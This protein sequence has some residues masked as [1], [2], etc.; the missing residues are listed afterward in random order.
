V[1]LPIESLR[2]DGGTQ[3]RAYITPDIAY[4]YGDEMQAGAKFPP[5]VVFY[6][7]TD[8]WLADGFHRVEG[9][10]SVGIEQIECDVR[11][12][13]VE[14]A[15]WLSF[16]VNALHGL[17]RNKDDKQRAVRAALAHPKASTMSD[18]QIA[19][20]CGVSRKMIVEYRGL[21][22]NRV[23]SRT[24]RDGRTIN[25][26]NIGR[27]KEDIGAALEAVP[28]EEQRAVLSEGQKRVI[29]RAKE[30]RTEK[31]K[32]RSTNTR[33]VTISASDMFVA[34]LKEIIAIYER[35]SGTTVQTLSVIHGEDGDVV[36]IEIEAE[37]VAHLTREEES[38]AQKGEEALPPTK[39]QQIIENAAKQQMIRAISAIRGACAGLSEINVEALLSGCTARDL[40]EW[41]GIAAELAVALRAF[42]SQLTKCSGISHCA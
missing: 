34:R 7:G 1:L 6:D 26:A 11:Q 12:G 32:V 2:Q 33:P 39:R 37:I 29:E 18:A 22:C 23:T 40:A 16:G 42:G 15:Q 3:P 38:T 25:T 30:V 35:G 27:R 5:V 21:T 28:H 9:A 19:E 17:R 20:H 4:E 31:R 24:G 41:A 8:H 13:T 10:F 36:D 14:D